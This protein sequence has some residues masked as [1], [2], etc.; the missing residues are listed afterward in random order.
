MKPIYSIPKVSKTTSLW[1]VH[2]RYEGKQFRYK[3]N[4]NKIEDLEERAE[5]FNRLCIA[6]YEKL[7]SGWNPNLKEVPEMGTNY[8][9][10]E[11]LDFALSKKKPNISKKTALGYEGTIKFIKTA[12]KQLRLINLPITEVKRVHIKTIMEKAQSNRC[13]TN[14]AYNK[15]LNQLKAVMSELI[16]YDIIESNPAHNIKN[17]RIEESIAHA[18]ATD[19]QMKAIKKELLENHYN[20][21]IFILLIYNL[22]IR[23]EE[24]LKITLDMIDLDADLIVLPPNITKG[25][26]KY[27]TLPITKQLKT[28]LE[29]LN[30]EELPKSYYLFGSFRQ[31]GKGNVGASVDFIPAP[32]PLKRDTA[33]K[34]WHKIVKVGLGINVTMY[35]M[36]KYGANKKAEAGISIDAIQGTFGH[37]KKETTLIYLTKQ[38]EI[39][40][41]EIMDKSPDL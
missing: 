31:Q 35:S 8:T 11:A 12:T 9:F 38:N 33:T 40:R 24:I 5:S 23:P 22:G 41:K 3:M 4:L 21:Y 34:R 26:K 32:T 37:S 39:N 2:F 17:L 1:Y 18:P 30:F 16:Q 27:R 10:L 36:K 19:E 6:I 28:F 15:H 7:R 13:W 14:N 29:S 20:F 25:R